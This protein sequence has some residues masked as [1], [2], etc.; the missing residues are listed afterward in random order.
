MA[1]HDRPKPSVWSA[2]DWAHFF[3]ALAYQ[4]DEGAALILGPKIV[5]TNVMKDATTGDDTWQVWKPTGERTMEASFT[6]VHGGPAP[7][8]ADDGRARQLE[9]LP[10]RLLDDKGGGENG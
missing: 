9:V 5:L 7:G 6:V 8:L 10:P 2:A 3:R 1:K 4:L